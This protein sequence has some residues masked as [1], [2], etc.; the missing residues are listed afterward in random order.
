MEAVDSTT[1]LTDREKKLIQGSR[2]VLL[3]NAAKTSV[4]ISLKWVENLVFLF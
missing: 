4:E 3:K 1:G 2:D